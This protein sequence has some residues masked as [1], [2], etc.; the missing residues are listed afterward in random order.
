MF[1]SRIE[2]ADQVDHDQRTFKCLACDYSETVT[3]RLQ[4]DG[5]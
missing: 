2:P 4:T 3:D 5:C 1:L